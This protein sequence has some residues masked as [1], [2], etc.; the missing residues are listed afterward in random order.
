[1]SEI[2]DAIEEKQPLSGERRDPHAGVV[3]RALSIPPVV[4]KVL[5]R[6]PPRLYHV[7]FTNTDLSM[8]NIQAGAADS[9]LDCISRYSRAAR[10]EAYRR[11]SPEF[12][13]SSAAPASLLSRRA[14]ALL[15]KSRASP[16]I[17]N[18]YARRSQEKS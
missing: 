5:P 7:I 10:D 9:D 4:D 11:R 18:K 3:R 17:P 15:A 8:N 12:R 1:M 16:N 6:Q 13:A 14:P 2:E